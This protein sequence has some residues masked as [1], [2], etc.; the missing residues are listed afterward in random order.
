MAEKIYKTDMM[1]HYN[2]IVKENDAIEYGVEN[3]KRYTKNGLFR[4]R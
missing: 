1:L 4:S 2:D 3:D